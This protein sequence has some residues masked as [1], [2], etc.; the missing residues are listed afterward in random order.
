MEDFADSYLRGE[1]PIPCVRCNQTVKFVDM[2][3]RAKQL[4]ASAMA[5]GTLYSEE[6][7]FSGYPNLFKGLR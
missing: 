2:V 5:T 3:E 4:G 7:S 1:T 6:K